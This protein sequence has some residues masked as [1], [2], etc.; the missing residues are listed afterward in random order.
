[1]GQAWLI[2]WVD[3]YFVVKS[4]DAIFMSRQGI[5]LPF[6]IIMLDDPKNN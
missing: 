1:M 4:S 2:I 5:K 6:V 3:I